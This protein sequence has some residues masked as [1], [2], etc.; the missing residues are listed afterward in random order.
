MSPICEVL[1]TWCGIVAISFVV[2]VVNHGFRNI[3]LSGWIVFTLSRRIITVTAI[4]L[5]V[6]RSASAKEVESN[7]RH[8][9]SEG[10]GMLELCC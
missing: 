6:C 2:L 3:H 9:Y 4:V 8:S 10:W 7:A 1:G 5:M